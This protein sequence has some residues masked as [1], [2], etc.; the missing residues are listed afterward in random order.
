MESHCLAS[1]NKKLWDS[2]KAMTNM[3]PS[4]RCVNV[5]NERDTAND[6]NIFFSVDSKQET[7]Q[8]Q[9][10]ALDGVPALNSPSR[11]LEQI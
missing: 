6:L 10:A 7:P 1:N 9:K 8:E 3:A 4:K 5:I 11:I 2:V